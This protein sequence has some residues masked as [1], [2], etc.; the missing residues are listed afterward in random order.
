MKISDKAQTKSQDLVAAQ[1]VSK[2]RGR[3]P[4]FQREQALDKALQVF[5]R[6]GY[7]GA[8]LSEL[9]SALGINRPSLYAAFGNK[10]D[11]FHKVLERY[12]QGPVA[13]AAT[14]LQEPTAR[15]VVEKFLNDSV[16]L[17]TNADHP[18]GCMIV[19]AALTCGEGG[20]AVSR[21]LV[22]YRHQFQDALRLRLEQ[23]QAEGDLHPPPSEAGLLSGAGG[24]STEYGLAY[25]AELARYI[26]TVHQ[27][28]SVQASSGASRD[29]LMRVVAMVMRHW[30][31]D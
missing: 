14:A 3:P 10:E 16:Q 9:T 11:L 31:S 4:A 26:A 22:E 7:E 15:R 20:E 8:S 18:R 27:G 30:P 5:W 21:T 24:I 29:E 28:L 12:V 25:P 6:R 17:L 19:Q 23:A 13:Y 2:T 1:P